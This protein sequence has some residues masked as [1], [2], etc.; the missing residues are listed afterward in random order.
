MPGYV[1]PIMRAGGNTS[2]QTPATGT[3][4]AP[5]PQQS[6]RQLTVVND[7]GTA[8]EV[9]QDGAGVA[10]P[11]PTGT[12]FTFYG[13]GDASQMEVRRADTSGTQVTVKARW[14]GDI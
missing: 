14:E 11:L 3:N 9:R 6:C 1:T 4:W 12:F 5:F 10:I 2:V 13:I 8:L 7:T